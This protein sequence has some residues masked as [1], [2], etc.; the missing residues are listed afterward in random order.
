MSKRIVISDRDYKKIKEI[1]AR[2]ETGSIKET[3]SYLINVDEMSSYKNR[4]GV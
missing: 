1:M 4:A 3:I 2:E